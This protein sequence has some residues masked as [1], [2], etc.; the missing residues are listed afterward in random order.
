MAFPLR[1]R[2]SDEEIISL[3]EF[4]Q[5]KEPTPQLEEHRL[6]FP[7]LPWG[8]GSVLE[9]FVIGPVA[10]RGSAFVSKLIEPVFL[11][12]PGVLTE[13]TIKGTRQYFAL[14]GYDADAIFTVAK[15]IRY[16]MAPPPEFPESTLS[17]TDRVLL[18]EF[19]SSPF[20]EIEKLSPKLKELIEEKTKQERQRRFTVELP[21]WDDLIKIRTEVEITPEDKLAWKT[22][23]AAARRR[24]AV[25]LIFDKTVFELAE[26]LAGP[27]PITQDQ[28]DSLERKYKIATKI[29]ESPT[30]ELVRTIGNI[31][32][33]IDD[34]QDGLV[35]LSYLARV[36]MI[37]MAKVAPRVALRGV[38]IIGW[39]TAAKSLFDIFSVFRFL[40][41]AR[42][43]KKRQIW[44]A[45]EVMAKMKSSKLR[46]ALKM[47]A[48]LPTWREL[49]QIFQTTDVLFGKGFAVGPIV[50]LAED[51]TFGLFRGAEFKF[52]DR[53][54][55]VPSISAY[56]Q[57]IFTAGIASPN[58]TPASLAAMKILGKAPML[59]RMG[60]E[61]PLEYQL[62][63]F[64][65]LHFAATY[66]EKTQDLGD[67][68]VWAKPLIDTPFAPNVVGDTAKIVLDEIP[69]AV[70][71][72]QEPWPW[73][74]MT[75]EITPRMKSALLQAE[76]P[77]KIN[78]FMSSINTLEESK[79]LSTLISECTECLFRAYEG[80]DVVID[81][82]LTPEVRAYYLIH[83]Y[84][85]E[86]ELG[87]PEDLEIALAGQVTDMLIRR[88]HK[89]PTFQ[90][91][92]AL[93]DL[94]KL[95]K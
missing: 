29:H 90:E 4:L 23:R 44:D 38:P 14:I 70:I 68:D 19:L 37:I 13:L 18:G 17:K 88:Q 50:G 24:G 66:L 40:R 11:G 1:Q 30:P 83:E 57:N 49:I 43:K 58:L 34:V 72:D 7:Y 16:L 61:L 6:V 42:S 39:V 78:E 41:L 80:P 89:S 81:K 32:G 64:T 2:L 21:G 53:S 45:V 5:T 74:D 93:V 76:L 54:F 31:L 10:G 75:D 91:V 35:T 95:L 48:L 36:G 73:L 22:W 82:R 87:T 79:Y 85:L 77:G 71:Q 28:I 59:I 94:F 52:L 46:R 60:K 9:V 69:G 62:Q 8:Y 33:A 92:K 47:G 15:W 86:G 51:V 84:G 12:D 65:A 26:R 27:A 63:T 56:L 25:G 67:W 20:E 3:I 55:K